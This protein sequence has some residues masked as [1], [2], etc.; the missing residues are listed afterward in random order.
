MQKPALI[1]RRHVYTHHARRDAREFLARFVIDNSKQLMRTRNGEIVWPLGGSALEIPHRLERFDFS[2]ELAQL[3]AVEI[4][5][6]ERDLANAPGVIRWQGHVTEHLG[7][8]GLSPRRVA[9]DREHDLSAI[10]P[11]LRLEFFHELNPAEI[12]GL[13][14]R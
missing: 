3:L 14:N 9:A 5:N 10:P 12:R 6:A 8:F 13:L 1:T 11:V 7:L 4:E 2:L